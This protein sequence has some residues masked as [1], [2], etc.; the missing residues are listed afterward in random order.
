MVVVD[1]ARVNEFVSKNP[2]Y[3]VDLLHKQMSKTSIFWLFFTPCFNSI[4]KSG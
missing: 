4:E 3:F 2:F 1:H